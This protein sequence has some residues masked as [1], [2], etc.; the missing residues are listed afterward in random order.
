MS[1]ADP[2]AGSE[3][4]PV[5]DDEA[6][7]L[8]RELMARVQAGDGAALGR[9]MQRWERPVKAVIGRLVGNAAEAEE[10]AQEAFVRLWQRRDLFRAGSE[11]RPWMLS[12]ALNLARNRLRWWRRRPL[13]ALDEWTPVPP[14]D[15]A[16]G[17]GTLESR[18]R[19]EAVRAAVADLPLE[20]REALVLF[21][22]EGLGQAEIAEIAGTTPKAIERRLDRARAALR[23]TLERWLRRA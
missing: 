3:P 18:E 14:A 17:A 5:A 9:L 12:L 6:A 16:D 8:D 11:F 20:Q 1:P 15:G 22:Y 23:V 19:A 4:R 7:I 2:P 10:L 21:E 13:V